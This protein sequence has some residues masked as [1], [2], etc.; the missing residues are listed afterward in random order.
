MIVPILPVAPLPAVGVVPAGTVRAGHF[1]MQ[2][3]VQAGRPRE[4]LFMPG[5]WYVIS[6]ESFL[7]RIETVPDTV[8]LA[9]QVKCPVLCIRGDKEPRDRYPAEEFQA[10]AGGSCKV[11]IVP[12]CDHFYNGCED[13]VANHVAN[14]LTQM[15]V[16]HTLKQQANNRQ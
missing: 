7:D 9:P 6:A 10:R 2:A 1:V 13:V 5:W 12:N 14:F 16:L 4:L 15:R 8:A 11:E 3:A